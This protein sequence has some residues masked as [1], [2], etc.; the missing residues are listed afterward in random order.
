VRERHLPLPPL[1]NEGPLIPLHGNFPK[2][3]NTLI[4]LLRSLLLKVPY[5]QYDFCISCRAVVDHSLG[6]NLP[7]VEVDN[8]ESI[9]GQGL[10]AVVN[11]EV[12]LHILHLLTEL[13]SA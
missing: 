9:P 2:S 3:F 1:W 11:V 10:A 6:K 13:Y 4:I 12:S 8:F 5:S 7:G